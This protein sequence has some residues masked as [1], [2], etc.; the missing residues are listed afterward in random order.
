MLSEKWTIDVSTNNVSKIENVGGSHK[1]KENKPGKNL[2]EYI[3]DIS[4][5]HDYPNTIECRTIKY[6][7]KN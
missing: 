1:N 5:C 6:T 3:Y 4:V 2:V 7:P